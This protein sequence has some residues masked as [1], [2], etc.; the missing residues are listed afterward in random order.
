MKLTAFVLLLSS[1]L[2]PAGV[3]PKKKEP[4][5]SA[6]DQYI[7]DAET[8][9]TTEGAATTVGSTWVSYSPMTDLT[10]DPRASRVDDVV[11]IVVSES[12][13]AATTGNTQT[14]RKSSTKTTIT[15]LPGIKSPAAHALISA[16][17]SM[18]GETDLNGQGT[19]SRTT[20]LTTSLTARVSKVLPNGFLVIEGTKNIQINQE[21]QTIS[22]RGVVRPADLTNNNT[23]PSSRVAD[24]DVK[25]DGKGVVKDAIRRPNFLYR[26]LLGVLPF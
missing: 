10:R 14:S 9:A 23:V 2:A 13:S 22:V 19:T 1:M 12:A 25:L 16:M 3:I 18:S 21:W 8:R 5:P 6:V 20:T 24:L 26:L 15:S 4:P 17:P 11:T 7:R